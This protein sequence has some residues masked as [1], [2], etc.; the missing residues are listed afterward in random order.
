[1]KSRLPI[2]FIQSTALHHKLGKVPCLIKKIQVS[3]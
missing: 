2:M 3:R 1:M